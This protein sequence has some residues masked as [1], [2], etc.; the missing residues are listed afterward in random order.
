MSHPSRGAWIEIGL[1][2]AAPKTLRSHPSRGAW[3]EM[4]SLSALVISCVGRTPHGVR[5]LKCTMLTTGVTIW[6][7]HPSRGAWIEMLISRMK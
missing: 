1:A 3:I 6:M 4:T 2:T 7:S 5:G